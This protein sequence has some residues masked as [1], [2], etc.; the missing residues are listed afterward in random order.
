M[1]ETLKRD[2]SINTPPSQRD[3][4][5]IA[6][7]TSGDT[8]A[9]GT[10]VTRYKARIFRV[11]YTITRNQEDAE[12]VT[13][14]VFFKAFLRLRSFEGRSTF[15]TWLTRITVNE[16]LMQ[17]RRRGGVLL[18]LDEPT[19]GNGKNEAI[20]VPDPGPA[21]EQ[22]C[23]LNESQRFLESALDRLHPKLR[24]VFV[25]HKEGYSG[26]ETA[27]I[28]GLSIEATKT[29]LFRARLA[30]RSQLNRLLSP[31]SLP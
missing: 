13:Q 26:K 20:E 3:D 31:C 24:L 2:T 25:L 10:L 28:L 8:E 15:L 17:L 19:D 5:L 6:A 22:L 30:L 21:P 23:S 18:S 27:E 14:I 4:E 11:A 29:R 1:L 16:S 12:D 7:T 9:F